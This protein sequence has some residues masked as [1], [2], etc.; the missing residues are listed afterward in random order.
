MKRD[1]INLIDFTKEE[2]L[3]IIKRA[4][5]FKK[6]RHS[7]SKSRK[8]LDRKTIALIFEKSSTRTR[9]SFEVAI[10]ELG[11]IPIFLN[12]RDIQMGRG[13]PI[14]DTARVLSSYLHGIVYRCF[15]H[16]MLCE[17]AKYS[18]IPVINGLSDYSHPVQVLS[19][20]FTLY[21]HFGDI[22]KLNIA[23]VG[24]GNNMANSWIEAH[25]IFG[26]NLTMA[27]PKGYEPDHQLLKKAL[28][29]K[30][31]KLTNNPVEA[32]YGADVINTDVWISMGD[33]E[34]SEQRKKD[35]KGFQVNKNLLK[36]AKKNAVVLHCLPAYRG[37]EIT[38]DVIESKQSLIF[39]QAENRLHAQ[40]ALLE[41]IFKKER[42]V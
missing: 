18:S 16:E 40:K 31:F 3:S 30:N 19:D 24:D 6:T 12:V 17:L 27:C 9:V 10:N 14:K 26:F 35:F 32:V 28:K 20:L 11:G 23:W 15:K 34:E 4:S 2:V 41:F 22:K 33:E 7:N 8:V 1:F 13:E 38:E 36:K 42:S 39:V 5:L 21:E 37:L 25:L 29:N